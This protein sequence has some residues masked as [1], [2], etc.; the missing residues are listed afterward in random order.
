MKM[1]NVLPF[2]CIT[3]VLTLSI[4]FVRIKLFQNH[5][6]IVHDPPSRKLMRAHHHKREILFYGDSLVAKMNSFSDIIGNI[7]NFLHYILII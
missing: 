6:V 7:W 4:I 1:N 3:V 5:D 2:I